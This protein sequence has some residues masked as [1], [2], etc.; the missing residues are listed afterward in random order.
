M[1]QQKQL[2]DKQNF[3]AMQKMEAN[4]LAAVVEIQ[5]D[6]ETKLKAQDAD[7]LALEQEKLEMKRRFV[8]KIEALQK[9]NKESIER[10]LEEFNVNLNKVQAEYEESKRTA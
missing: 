9:D 7:S 5:A 1:L 6:Y 2:Q 10:L 8:A 4:H 3:D